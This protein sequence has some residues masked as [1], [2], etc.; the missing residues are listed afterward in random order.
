MAR[1]AFTDESK[2][3]L[4]FAEGLKRIYRRRGKRFAQCCILEHNQWGVGGIM[5]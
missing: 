5:V 3:N 1:G 2:F 4:S